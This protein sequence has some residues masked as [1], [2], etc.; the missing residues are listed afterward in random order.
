MHMQQFQ[1]A[2]G[3]YESAADSESAADDESQAD[4][5]SAA[6][7]PAEQHMDGPSTDFK[8]QMSN[9]LL[10]LRTVLGFAAPQSDGQK[11]VR[12]CCF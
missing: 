10:E 11:L 9:V 5:A 7:E 12:P 4:D 6:E 2:E 3:H 1:G 8:Q